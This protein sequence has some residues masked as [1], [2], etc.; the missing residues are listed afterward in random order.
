MYGKEKVS[1]LCRGGAEER[2][3]SSIGLF[4]FRLVKLNC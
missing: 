1:V 4:T 3:V 2:S